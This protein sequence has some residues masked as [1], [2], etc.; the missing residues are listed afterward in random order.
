MK[1]R[2]TPGQICKV[3]LE[4]INRFRQVVVTC[5]SEEGF[6]AS[7]YHAVGAERLNVSKWQDETVERNRQS[8][9]RLT[10]ALPH[11]FPS[12]V[13]SHAYRRRRA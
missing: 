9:S 11:T 7:T 6:T 5:L 13:Q 12:V 2:L 4:Y 10:K 3:L 8:R 1:I